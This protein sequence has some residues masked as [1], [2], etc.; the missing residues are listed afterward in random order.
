LKFLTGAKRSRSQFSP[1]TASLTSHFGGWFLFGA[2][3]FLG[4]REGWR[5]SAAEGKIAVDD[6][7]EFS[8]V[9][10]VRIFAI[11]LGLTLVRG[12]AA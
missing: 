5:Q 6:T 1:N 3:W 7:T 8:G 12:S 11:N 4:R 2:G 10:R 9:L